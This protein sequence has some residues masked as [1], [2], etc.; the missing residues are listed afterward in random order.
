MQLVDGRGRLL[1]HL[2][3]VYRPGE[4]ELAKRSFEALGCKVHEGKGFLTASVDPNCLD[5]IDTV[6]YSSKVTR[7]Q[8]AFETA[9]AA[10]VEADAELGDA[11]RTYA[12]KLVA[13]PQ[14]S[15]HFGIRFATTSE[16]EDTV[17]RVEAAGADDPELAG[18]IR[19]A[20][21]FRPGDDGSMSD[22][23][24]QAFVSVDTFAAG[25]LVFPQHVELQ[26][27]LVPVS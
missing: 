2:E 23:V 12:D 21:M 20:G 13:V 5:G 14:R 17:A 24:C 26:H 27:W 9:L 25:L 6:I 7:E 10:A 4:M 11:W 19:V 8:W 3:T 1:N 22:K 16:W 18:R 15:F